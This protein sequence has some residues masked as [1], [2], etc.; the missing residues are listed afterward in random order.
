MIASRRPVVP[1]SCCAY[2]DR[3]RCIATYI[4]LVCE[5][6]HF[7]NRDSVSLW[8]AAAIRPGPLELGGAVLL[9]RIRKVRIECCELSHNGKQY[10]TEMHRICLL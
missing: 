5:S 2:R 10:R 7:F 4:V 8:A 9:R 3:Y 1:L 6:L